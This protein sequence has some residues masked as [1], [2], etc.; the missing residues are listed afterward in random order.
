MFSKKSLSALCVCAAIVS[1]AGANAAMDANLT[2]KR[3][4]YPGSMHSGTKQ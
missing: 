4:L 1:A 2:V 3:N